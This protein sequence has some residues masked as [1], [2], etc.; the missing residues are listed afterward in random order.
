LTS[1]ADRLS[2]NLWTAPPS[3]NPSALSGCRPV[4]T[5]H[6]DDAEVDLWSAD[7]SVSP[8]S[9]DA[10]GQFLSEDER[11]RSERFHSRDDAARFIAA[12]GLLRNI[13][14]HYAGLPPVR[15]RFR[16]GPFGKPALTPET[17][18]DRVRF[19]ASRSGRL[20]V[21]AVARGREIGIDVEKVRTGFDF[22]PIVRSFFSERER[23]ILRGL[24]FEERPGAFF[25][26]WTL[27]EAAAKGIGTGLSLP[28][29]RL[30]TSTAWEDPSKPI[31]IDNQ[32]E[33]SRWMLREWTDLPAGYRA[34]LA[35]RCR[36]E[37]NATPSAQVD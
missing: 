37:R 14:G 33:R 15:L 3:E 21:Y 16:P 4:T 11:A 23:T 36:Y 34:A 8:S 10:L 28:F 2:E 5:L 30:D 17:G 22:E 20:A 29:H 12:R 7:L 27:K 19:S 13:L 31:E 35:V 1:R 6:L 32:G 18:G 26:F 24:S 25:T 9:A